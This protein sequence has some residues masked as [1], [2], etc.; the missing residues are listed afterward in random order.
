MVGALVGASLSA[1]ALGAEMTLEGRF[2]DPPARGAGPSVTLRLEP[3]RMEAGGVLRLAGRVRELGAGG[4]L[5]A[6]P[7]ADEAAWRLLRQLGESCQQSGL[8]LGICDFPGES[9]EAAGRSR[10]RRLV[11]SSRTVDGAGL[12]TNR[13][14]EFARGGAAREVACL[15][16][17]VAESVL[18]HQVVDLNK[19]PLPAEGS[20]RVMRFASVE[21]APQ[22]PDAFDEP[23]VFRHVNQTL[24]ALQSQ[25]KSCYGT[26]L[27]WYQCA[28]AARGERVWPGDMESLFLKRSGLGLLRHLPAL[29][30]VSVGGAATAAH[31]RRQVEATVREAWRSRYALNVRDLVQEAGLEAG[32][33]VGEVPVEPEEVAL[34]F[35]RPLVTAARDEAQRAVNVRAAGAA[36]ACARRVIVGRLSLA[37]VAATPDSAL[38]AFPFKHEMDGL[39]ADGATRILLEA[40]NAVW[41]DDARYGQLR[42]ACVYARRC[43]LLLQHG[44][45]AADYLV[46][47][48]DCPPLLDGYACDRACQALLEA[49][50][51]RAGAIHLPSG[52]AYRALVA[53]AAALRDPDAERVVRQLAD[54]GLALWVVG[55]GTPDGVALVERDAA[56]EKR[57]GRRFQE[58]IDGGAQPDFAWH[59]AAGGMRLRS[60]HRRSPQE[61]VYFVVNDSA[62]GGPVTAVF[63][64]T[65]KGVPE[66][67]DP[68]GGD[69]SVLEEFERRPDGRLAVS[70]YLGP[71]DACFVVFDR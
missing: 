52:R 11:W 60:L 59:A 47:A 66:R 6:L 8:E 39:F 28:G 22:V 20:W 46:W 15:A 7:V 53:S 44:E 43:Q 38:M 50:T 57:S 24:F 49:S 30:G 56:G 31:V 3:E 12:A 33:A 17:P 34:Y 51:V 45:P 37:S 2:R 29:D 1:A 16:V 42:A 19:A 68:Q 48:E 26:T 14:P 32:I 13:P 71:H 27:V 69:V 35:R 62:A 65:G 58:A 18:P 64:D 63:R 55:D 4:V 10:A 70:L 54:K 23:A 36:R 61:E 25:L 9:A 41:D 67:W 40:D 21:V 5:A